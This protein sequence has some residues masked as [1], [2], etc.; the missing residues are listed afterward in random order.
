MLMNGVLA[1]ASLHT[2]TILEP[3]KASI[4][5]DI[6]LENHSFRIEPFCMEVDNLT[7][8]NRDAIFVRSVVQTAINLPLSQLNVSRAGMQSIS[9]PY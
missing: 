5:I 4:Y 6:G 3:A 7:S 2:V 1:L 8:N 9:V